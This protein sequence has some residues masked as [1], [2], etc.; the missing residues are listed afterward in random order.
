MYFCRIFLTFVS[1]SIRLDLIRD[2][3]KNRNQIVKL[4]KYLTISFYF[5]QA[6]QVLDEFYQ[7]VLT[8]HSYLQI[9]IHNKDR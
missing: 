1:T 4:K 8:I 3:N 2:N 9:W 6:T 5:L 7:Y